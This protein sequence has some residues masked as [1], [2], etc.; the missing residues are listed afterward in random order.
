MEIRLGLRSLFNNG[1]D[2]MTAASLSNNMFSASRSET[3][4]DVV[5][6]GVAAAWGGIW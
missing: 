6:S 1:L 4:A 2:N 5:S 3:Y